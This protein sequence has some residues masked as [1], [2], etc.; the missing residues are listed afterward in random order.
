MDRDELMSEVA[1]DPVV[2]EHYTGFQ[3]QRTQL[4]KLQQDLLVH[5]SYRMRDKVYWT[6]QKVNIK[7][8]ETL[9]SDGTQ[10]ARTRCGNRISVLAQEP[11]LPE[12]PPTESFEMPIIPE[13]VP[14]ALEIADTFPLPV[15]TPQTFM[16]PP[17]AFQ[18]PAY[19]SYP[20]G[21]P[22]FDWP[23]RPPS[24]KI[25]PFDGDGGDSGVPE[26]GSLILLGSGLALGILL[27]RRRSQ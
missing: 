24:G 5:V 27:Y 22:R 12:E 6:K 13:E 16:F 2:A 21:R 18:T 11:T 9:V 14:S 17:V 1:R 3:V 10:S 25:T 26:P 8:G 20:P 19:I 15:G 23:Y 7:R 4:V